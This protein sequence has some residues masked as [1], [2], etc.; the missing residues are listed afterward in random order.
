MSRNHS[1]RDAESSL[2]PGRRQ[3]LKTGAALSVGSMLVPQS[4]LVR[5]APGRTIELPGA[6]ELV[7][8][9]MP[10]GFSRSEMERRWTKLRAWMSRE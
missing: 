10:K 4:H 1:H 3:L 5:A 8:T 6:N 7:A 9:N 2:K